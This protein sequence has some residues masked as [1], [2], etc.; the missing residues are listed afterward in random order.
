MYTVSILPPRP[1]RVSCPVEV[2]L[3]E[4]DRPQTVLTGH[5]KALN[6]SE[7]DYAK[8]LDQLRTADLATIRQASDTGDGQST[9]DVAIDPSEGPHARLERLE[10]RERLAKA[11]QQLPERERQILALYYEEEL[12]LA[13]I[14]EVIGVGESR[15]S[16][17]R[18]QAIARLRSILSTS[19]EQKKTH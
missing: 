16:Q 2:R 14:G 18:S 5:A 10:L 4:L 3:L 12:T 13:E 7:A 1:R 15:V 8:M 19:L 6:V 9:L 11:I 17:L